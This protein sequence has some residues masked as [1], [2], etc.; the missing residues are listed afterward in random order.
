MITSFTFDLNKD[1]KH[2]INDIYSDV[3]SLKIFQD[4]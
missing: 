3:P 2:I 4:D 1:L